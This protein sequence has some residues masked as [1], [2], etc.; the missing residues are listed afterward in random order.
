MIYGN[1]FL[2]IFDKFY[3]YFTLNEKLTNFSNTGCQN[4]YS[5][6]STTDSVISFSKF[7]FF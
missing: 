4:P 1:K 6:G 5:T 3:I 2:Y 7:I